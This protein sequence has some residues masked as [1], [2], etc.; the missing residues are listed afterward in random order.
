VCEQQ[1]IAMRGGVKAAVGASATGEFFRVLAFDAV[2]LGAGVLGA[3][4]EK[5]AVGKDGVV[6]P[7]AIEVGAEALRCAAVCG[8]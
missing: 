1:S 7:V 8:D 6:L 2:D 5:R 4:G 3:G